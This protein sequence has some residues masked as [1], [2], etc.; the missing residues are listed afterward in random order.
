MHQASLDNGDLPD[1]VVK[2][3]R[4][5]L[6]GVPDLAND[7]A[8]AFSLEYYL[9]L[10]YSANVVYNSARILV[11]KYFNIDMLSLDQVKRK[12]EELTGI[13]PIYTDMCIN[14]C[15]AFSGPFAR[16]D[17]CPLCSEPR[18]DNRDEQRVPRKQCVT[19][20][21]GPQIQAAYRSRES[22]QAMRYRGDLT[23]KI[24]S[25][26]H[27]IP[28]FELS[29]YSDYIHSSQYL[30]ACDREDVTENDTVLLF[31]IDGAQL[32]R[33]K[34][35]DCWIYIWVILDRHPSNR[36]KNKHIL[37]GGVVPGPRKPKNI[38]SFLFPGFHHVAALMKEGFR[39]WRADT[40]VIFTSNPFIPFFLGDGPGIALLNGLV[41][42]HGRCGCRL[43]CALVGRHKP[44]AG[45]HY[46]PVLKKPVDVT[47]SAHQ[48]SQ[49]ADID[50][51]IPLYSDSEDWIQ[52]YSRNLDTVLHAP[53]NAAYE[54]ARRNTGITKPTLVS[55]FPSNRIF[56]I[57]L[58]F[59][60]DIMH[61]AGIQIPDLIIPLFRG[62]LQCTLPDK[63]ETWD[64]AVLRS[65]EKW[66]AH[67]AIVAATKP[68]L[69]SS[70]DRPPRNIAEK[71]TSGYKAAE[72]LTYLY[73]L[74]PAILFGVLPMPY[75]R[76][77]CKMI[78]GV[79]IIYRY[80]KKGGI[81][82]GDLAEAHKLLTEF[83]IEF[84]DLYYQRKVSRLHFV[85]QSIHG[86]V[87]LASETINTGP[88]PIK[89]QWPI[90][91]TIGILGGQIRQP[92]KPYANLAQR[93]IRRC[94]VNALKHIYPNH[95][96]DAYG[97]P[98]PRG[99]YDVGDG[100]VLKRFRDRRPHTLRPC[101]AEVLCD[102]VRTQGMA[103]NPE[104]LATPSVIRWARLQLPTGQLAGA[105]KEKDKHLADRRTRRMV[106]V[107]KHGL[108]S[109]AYE[110][111]ED[112]SC[113]FTSIRYPT[114]EKWKLQKSIFTSSLTWRLNLPEM[115]VKRSPW[116]P[117]LVH[118]MQNC[119]NFLRRHTGLVLSPGTTGWLSST[120][121]QSTRQLLSFHKM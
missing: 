42:H 2:H 58:C 28:D 116:Y 72:F 1:H 9:R 86:L 73:G 101:E 48:A 32:Y 66:A 14:T 108:T 34:E 84:E 93:A 19:I 120:S 30:Y 65:A 50:I 4:E 5:P 17:A 98:L 64:W 3:L 77:L 79:R 114:M 63:V 110:N 61:L 94:Q 67:G 78:R 13:I 21:V 104:W 62:T 121:R 80:K 25:N 100:Y 109:I 57:P 12:A 56:P 107:S 95:D 46:Y 45:G 18:F 54:R 55:G 49:H 92:S 75:W 113:L 82:S 16:L 23:K 106:E 115:N 44:G 105:W 111:F 118:L 33:M 37:I 112:D 52:R 87:H 117:S 43:Y 47:G 41:G 90:E 38:E 74:G 89:S 40:N 53:S 59:P 6:V 60:A 71:L 27:N 36:Y 69:P 11:K 103:T 10:D 91:R 51:T 88:Y 99:A 102:F 83:V 119:L 70:F 8:L 81:S 97:S 85:R 76:N 35:S 20:P 68:Y 15:A 31:S 7:R 29:T 24:L 39:I 22:A 96:P 26:L